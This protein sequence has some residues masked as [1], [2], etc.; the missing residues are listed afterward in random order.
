V[1]ASNARRGK[2]WVG[3][4]GEETEE[5]EGKGGEG[6]RRGRGREGKGQG[7]QPPK[8]FTTHSCIHC[9]V[10]EITIISETR[11]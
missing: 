8:D 9:M 7:L 3:W 5:R 6:R 11:Q 10:V 4:G 2:G 1:A